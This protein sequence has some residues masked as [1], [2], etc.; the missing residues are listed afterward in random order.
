MST[1]EIPQEVD[2]IVVPEDLRNRINTIAREAAEDLQDAKLD[3]TTIQTVL[4]R[5]VM[6]TATL[7]E[8]PI[9]RTLEEVSGEVRASNTYTLGNTAEG[10]YLV[11]FTM[12]AKKKIT[13]RYRPA[14]AETR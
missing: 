8:A 6:N 10:A 4:R 3:R 11:W 12:D 7:I 2:V 13:I 1:R 14:Q 9:V 5:M